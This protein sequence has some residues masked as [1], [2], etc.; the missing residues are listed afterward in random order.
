MEGSPHNCHEL[1]KL[2]TRYN[3][4]SHIP[5]LKFPYTM[6]IIWNWKSRIH[7]FKI[8]CSFVT[9]DGMSLDLI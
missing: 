3:D 6:T 8:K 4:Q 7:I 1:I 9:L 5:E 2:Y